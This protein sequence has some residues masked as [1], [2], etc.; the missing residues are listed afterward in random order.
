MRKNIAVFFTILLTCSLLVESAYSK[1]S[2]KVR[3]TDRPSLVFPEPYLPILQAERRVLG[4]ID[5]SDLTKPTT[6]LVEKEENNNNSSLETITASMDNQTD[7]SNDSSL[8]NQNMSQLQDQT[9]LSGYGNSLNRKIPVLVLEYYPDEDQDGFLDYIAGDARYQSVVDKKNQVATWNQELVINLEEASRYKGY[10]DPTAIGSLDYEIRKKL[11][12]DEPI[13]RSVVYAPFADH[14]EVLANQVDICSEIDQLGIKEVWIWMY[15]NDPAGTADDIV[16]IE[17]NMSGPYGDISNSYRQPDLPIC[18]ST[19]TVYNYNYGRGMGEAVEN[20]THQIEALLNHVDGRHLTPS[21]QW[22]ELLF[23][24]KFV[25]SDSSHR[26]VNPG[27][28]WT[29]YPPNGETDYDWGN[30]TYAMTN[31]QDWHPDGSGEHL[32]LNCQTWN[33]NGLDFK[34]W[35][36][37]NIPGYDNGLE[38]QGRWLRNW[39]DF[40]ADFDQAMSMGQSLTQDN[41]LQEALDGSINEA[42]LSGPAPLEVDF[43]AFAPTAGRTY[44]WVFGDGNLSI[45]ANPIHTYQEAGRYKVLL[46]SIDQNQTVE[47]N[48]LMTV[49]VN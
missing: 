15:H 4:E 8:F 13:P 18:S 1:Q 12:F 28:G 32:S 43:S 23:W 2:V 9:T 49:V 36:M 11:I 41:P 47:T 10:K 46:N 26:I 48:H 17:S 19:Y 14:F 20:H 21:Y 24:G 30:T 37:Q 39:W 29:H 22:P 27:C 34:I 42:Y 3:G 16:P 31:C 40:V 5:I 7:W 45:A 38:Y 25:G 35:W 6:S 33:C 44:Q